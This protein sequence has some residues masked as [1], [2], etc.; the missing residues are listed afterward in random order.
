MEK[1]SVIG[2]IRRE[3]SLSW[4]VVLKLRSRDQLILLYFDSF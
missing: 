2:L 3:T 1:V 4:T